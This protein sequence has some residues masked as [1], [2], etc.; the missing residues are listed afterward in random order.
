MEWRCG[1]SFTTVL[2]VR[3]FLADS[4]PQPHQDT[5]DNTQA[6]EL[7]ESL[8]GEGSEGAGNFETH[9]ASIDFCSRYFCLHGL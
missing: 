3:Y 2:G 6:G 5:S 7:N 1:F 4:D 9:H 8:D